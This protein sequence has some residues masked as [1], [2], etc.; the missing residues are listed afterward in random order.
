MIQ[1]SL[2]FLTSLLNNAAFGYKIP[3]AVHI[4]FRS[5]GLVTNLILGMLL[6][7]KK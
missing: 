2:F 7:S 4:I 1:V 6:A 3:M 5:A